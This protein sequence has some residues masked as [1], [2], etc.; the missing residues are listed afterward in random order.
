MTLDSSDTWWQSIEDT[1]P[2]DG[3]GDDDGESSSNEDD[4]ETQIR[5]EVEGLK[6]EAKKPR[7]FQGVMLDIPCGA[8]TVLEMVPAQST[9]T[10]PLQWFSYVLIKP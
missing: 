10:K 9:Q 3:G 2:G 8:S 6:P 7:Q 5:K 1:A 4:I